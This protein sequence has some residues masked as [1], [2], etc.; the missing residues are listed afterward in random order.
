M[1]Q[2]IGE[3]M[4]MELTALAPSTIDQVVAP[5]GASSVWIGGSILSSLP[6]PADVDFKAEYGEAGPSIVHEH[7]PQCAPFNLVLLVEALVPL[8]I[9][10]RNL[11][12]QT[13][14]L[15]TS[16]CRRYE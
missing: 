14:T 5:P 8:V 4:T 11:L 10:Y 2:G 3:R 9:A 1:L 16:T 7:A 12:Y 15:C 13:C 6:P